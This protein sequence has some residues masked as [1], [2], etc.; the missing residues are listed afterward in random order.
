[1]K[2]NPPVDLVNKGQDSCV[3][4]LG[5][6]YRLE[7]KRWPN[8]RMMDDGWVYPDEGEPAV[9]DAGRE[10]ALPSELADAVTGEVYLV[11]AGWF[12]GKDPPPWRLVSW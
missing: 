10:E 3:T 11:N 6:S 8:C 7:W 2:P 5:R 12:W 4:A 1:M 9:Y